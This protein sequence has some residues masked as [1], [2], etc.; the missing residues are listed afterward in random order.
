MEAIRL[1]LVVLDPLLILPFRVPGP[2][3]VGYLLGIFV[4]CLWC[5]PLG[6]AT[7]LL[8]ARLN[9]GVYGRYAK[10]MVHHHNL[11]IRAAKT[12]DNANF[13]AV[14]KQA[15][16]AFGKYFFSQATVF[17]ATIW[18]VPF[19]LAWLDLRFREVFIPLPL[20]DFA[21]NYVFF[22]IPLYILARLLYPR[23]MFRIPWYRRLRMAA[24]FRMEERPEGLDDP[25]GGAGG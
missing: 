11:S 5:M 14:N 18:P 16:D 13:R 9:R 21:A 6:D 20:V 24:T 19:A 1:V 23:V 3:L 8:V 7:G 15:H 4:L 17:T 25:E 2:P 12:G 22:F 10:D